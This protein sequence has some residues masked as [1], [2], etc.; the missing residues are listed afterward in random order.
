M[1]RPSACGEVICTD[2]FYDK[3]GPVRS[4]QVLSDLFTNQGNGAHLMMH[5]LEQRSECVSSADTQAGGVDAGMAAQPFALEYILVHQPITHQED[6]A[7]TSSP[8]AV[9]EE[10]KQ[11]LGPSYRQQ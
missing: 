7:E 4:E 8:Q 11:G 6:K 10:A 2:L 3:K 9:R 5:G 1:L